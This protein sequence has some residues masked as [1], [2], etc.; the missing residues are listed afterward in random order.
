MGQNS[1]V[2]WTCSVC[3]EDRPCIL[4]YKINH[5]EDPEN[6]EDCPFGI[7]ISIWERIQEEDS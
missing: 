6:P 3:A 4:T 1:E 2:K 5:P 7:D